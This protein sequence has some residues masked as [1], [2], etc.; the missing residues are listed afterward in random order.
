MMSG[1]VRGR[2]RMLDGSLIGKP[3]SNTILDTRTYEIEL[4]DGETAELA[5]NVIA[6]NMYAMCD[7]EGNNQYLLLAGIVDHRNNE[8]EI[9][10]ADMYIQRGSDRHMRKTTKGWRLCIKWKEL[11]LILG[12]PCQPQG[13]QSRRCG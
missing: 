12:M 8:S 11:E 5:A 2:M 9:E 6:Q 13:I 10:K 7:L 3:N 1:K 4:A